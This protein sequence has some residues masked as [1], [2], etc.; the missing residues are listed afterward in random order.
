MQIPSDRLYDIV[1][2][3]SLID[4]TNVMHHMTMYGCTGDLN[5]LQVMAISN[6]LIYYKT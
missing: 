1:A 5:E 2:S 3:K 4:N 6:I